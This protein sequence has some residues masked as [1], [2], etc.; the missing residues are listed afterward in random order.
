[1]FPVAKNYNMELMNMNVNILF[2]GKKI[3]YYIY[4]FSIHD[5][6]FL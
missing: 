4:Y 1:M 5:W 3:E 6:D 2:F